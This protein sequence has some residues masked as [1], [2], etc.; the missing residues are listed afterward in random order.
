[1]SETAKALPL[2]VRSKTYR[3]AQW[4]TGRIGA[5]SLKAILS[6]PQFKLVGVYVH[7]AEKE[8]QD[9]G[10]LCGMPATGVKATRDIEKIIVAKPDCI[11]ANMEG[12]C[13]EDVCRFLEA[14]IN[15]VTSRVDYLD[16]DRMDQDLRKRVEAACAKGG[17]SIHSGGSSPGFSSEALPMVML[18]MSRRVDSITIDEFADIP[19]SC[20][21]YQT[22]DQMGF[23]RPHDGKDLDPRF[24]EHAA[25]GFR[26]SIN[27]LA[28]ALN[29]PL[30]S[31][32]VRGETAQAKQ[33]FLLPGGTPIEQGRVAAQRITVAGMRR[34]KAL[35]S[36]R[37]NWYTTFDIEADWEL[38]EN[39]WRVQVDSDTPMDVHIKF[40]DKPG[41]EPFKAAMAG[42]T[43]YQVLNAAPFVVE[44]AP[45]IRTTGELPTIVPDLRA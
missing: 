37:I 15:I 34:G 21:D 27:A 24:L 36:F 28:K 3:L 26:Q 19:A 29:A 14:G 20:P 43:A 30:D 9:A 40:R 39:G 23:G 13:G 4:A 11:V 22:V 17:A 10:D 18:S 5:V 8:G 12:P 35:I 2:P 41:E 38:R 33:R 42:L 6:S 25:H 44:A 16:P 45:G 31:I 32:E 1:M 7:S